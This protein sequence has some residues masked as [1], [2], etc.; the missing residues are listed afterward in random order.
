MPTVIRPMWEPKTAEQV[1]AAS[2][3]VL[4]GEAA[5]A[6]ERTMWLKVIEARE[7]GVADEYLCK[8][9]PGVSKTTLNRLFG[10][11]GSGRRPDWW[12]SPKI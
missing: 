10:P 5:L 1:L 11:R 2:V 4:A 7:M 6:A 12:D 8:R 9:V 3:A